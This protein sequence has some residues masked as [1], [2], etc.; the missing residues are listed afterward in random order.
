MDVYPV[1]ITRFGRSYYLI[2]C[3]NDDAHSDHVYM[4]NG[5][6]P[7]FDSLNQLQRFSKNRNLQ[8]KPAAAKI[9]LDVVARWMDE[10]SESP[11]SVILDAWN[12]LSDFHGVKLDAWR[13]FDEV[14]A[15][16]HGIHAALSEL[17]LHKYLLH[18]PPDECPGS[19]IEGLMEVMSAGLAAFD[20]TMELDEL[21]ATE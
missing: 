20:Q 1:H 18:A 21:P 9:D 19:F 16:H 13:R 10:N 3:G 5:V 15:R 6:V 2:W 17:V 8:T 4:E 14:S 12:L 11:H 7:T